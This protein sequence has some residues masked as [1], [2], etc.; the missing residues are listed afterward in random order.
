M[1][2]LKISWCDYIWTWYCVGPQ[3]VAHWVGGVG[4][5]GLRLFLSKCGCVSPQPVDYDRLVARLILE[6]MQHVHYVEKKEVNEADGSFHAVFRWTQLP[7]L[8]FDNE[9]RVVEPAKSKKGDQGGYKQG[10]LEITVELPAKRMV[11]A[12]LACEAACPGK[13]RTL[14]AKEA[15]ILLWFN[16]VLIFHPKVHA[17]ANWGVNTRNKANEYARTAAFITVMYNHFGYGVFPSLLTCY[18]R[19]RS[20]CCCCFRT[21][22]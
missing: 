5:M 2:Y 11:S 14:E 10:A 20:C 9:L 4:Y 1:D 22:D 7:L 19:T 21:V 8:T 13:V 16:T 12:T 6:S 15:V 18:S 17:Y 3:A